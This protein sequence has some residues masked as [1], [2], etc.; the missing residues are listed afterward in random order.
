MSM[1]QSDSVRRV[2]T[3]RIVFV[4]HDLL[5][6]DLPQLADE[7]A[8]ESWLLD[9]AG[10]MSAA[11]L[12]SPVANMPIDAAGSPRRAWRPPGAAARTAR[13]PGKPAAGRV[14]P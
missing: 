1:L 13:R 11:Q 8:R 6:A 7:T 3:A 2:R 12:E 10:I 5:A 14:P 4:N 9:Q